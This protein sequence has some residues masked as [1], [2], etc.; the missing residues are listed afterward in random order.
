MMRK[1]LLFVL[2]AVAACWAAEPYEWQALSI[3]AVFVAF[4]VLV[5]LYMLTYL[6]NS[7]EMRTMVSSEMYQVIFTLFIIAIFIGVEAF[8]AEVIGP[9]F[10]LDF[11]A[12]EGQNQIDYALEVTG[13]PDASDG[14]IAYQWGEMLSFANNVVSPLGTLSALSARCSFLGFSFGFAG[15]AGLAVP[16]ASASLAM[17]VLS[18]SLLMLNSQYF[19]LKLAQGFFF[20]VLL[21]VGLFLRS[22]H[23]TRGAGALL[24]AIAAAFYFMYPVGVLVTKGMADMVD[25]P[26]PDIPHFEAPDPTE[27]GEILGVDLPPDVDCNP[28]DNDYKYTKSAMNK[29]LDDD[30]LQPM[31][32]HFMIAGLLNTALSLMI[33]LSVVGGLARLFGAE[34]DVSALARMI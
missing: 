32:F 34:V 8:S 24:I 12:A 16:F 1:L 22:F 28:F 20:P 31:L 6:A 23:V 9:A 18:T 2:L 30:F 14:L 27:A 21:P 29:L 3:M 17:R 19:L 4:I 26:D 25:Y 10:G 13:G 7:P 11:G 33:A 15:C 5:I